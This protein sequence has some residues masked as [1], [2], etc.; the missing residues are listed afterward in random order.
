MNTIFSKIITLM[1]ISILSI[2]VFAAYDDT[3]ILNTIWAGIANEPALTDAKLVIKSDDGNVVLIG[4]LDT[5]DQ[6]DK[7]VSIANSTEGVKD[8][9]TDQL[10]VKNSNKPLSDTYITAKV[11]GLFTKEKLLGNKDVAVTSISVET[12]NGTVYLTG[13]VDNSQQAKNAIKLAQSVKGVKNV[14]SKIVV[15]SAK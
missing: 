13:K 3:I 5:D 9:N 10:L 8:V 15:S 1:L 2:P 6:A 4:N 14:D 12:K 11:K 7:V